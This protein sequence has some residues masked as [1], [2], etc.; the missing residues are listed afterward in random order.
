MV[1]PVYT[2]ARRH[3]SEAH[4]PHGDLRVDK[5]IVCQVTGSVDSPL[6]KMSV[7]VFVLLDQRFIGVRSFECHPEN[8]AK[9]R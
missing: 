8:R 5:Q 2:T 6:S 9:M 3:M 7:T 4:S 1:P